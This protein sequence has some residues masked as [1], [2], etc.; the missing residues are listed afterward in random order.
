MRDPHVESLTYRFEHRPDH[1]YQSP[2]P[3]NGCEGGFDY[4]LADD[5][6]T[7]T[8]TSHFGSELQAR[9]HVEPF[10][11]A[12]ELDQALS[13][14]QKFIWFAF[15]KS[16]VIDRNPPPPGSIVAMIGTGSMKFSCSGTLTTMTSNYPAPPTNIAFSNDVDTLWYRYELYLTGKEPLLSMAYF[17][18][19]LLEGTTGL[20]SGARAAV[21]T[22]YG[23]D[24][25]VR[26]KLGDLV[27]E[28]GDAKEAR[29]FNA[30]STGRKLKDV[31]RK[32]IEQVIK[33]LIRSKAEF[34][35][36]PKTTFSVIQLS[37]FV[38]LPS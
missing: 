23:I 38:V 30:T 29:K 2:P 8:M 37:D 7:L 31:E 19:S 28:A 4:T 5:V 22:K 21:C 3:I 33:A 17:C 15:E 36:D 25:A 1:V 27:S 12:W 6:L 11:R 34:D 24:Q 9:N 18:L 13:G 32:W 26:N 10:V 16:V 14:G 20:T 35:F